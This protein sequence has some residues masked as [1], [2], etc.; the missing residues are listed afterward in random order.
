MRIEVFYHPLILLCQKLGN[1]RF[2]KWP[3][4]AILKNWVSGRWPEFCHHNDFS[5]VF[6]SPCAKHHFL[7]R[8]TCG[9]AR[10]ALFIKFS[11]K[12]LVYSDFVFESLTIQF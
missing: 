12:I 11:V 10:L 1:I 4:D 8:N 6:V 2:S 7:N 3:P 5:H 9:F